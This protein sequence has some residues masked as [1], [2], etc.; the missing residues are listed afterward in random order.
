[1][2]WEKG[3][4]DQYLKWV[5]SDVANWFWFASNRIMAAPLFDWNGRKII[6]GNDFSAMPKRKK[7]FSVTVDVWRRTKRFFSFV[8]S[9]SRQDAHTFIK[10]SDRWHV[11]IIDHD[12]VDGG[13]WTDSRDLSSNKTPSTRNECEDERWTAMDDVVVV[14][15]IVEIPPRISLGWRTRPICSRKPS[16]C[17]RFL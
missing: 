13:M 12:H 9:L 4:G 7:D 17:Q 6:I 1:M 16:D 8:F 5:W 11:F 14:S 2:M 15:N 10:H 3:T